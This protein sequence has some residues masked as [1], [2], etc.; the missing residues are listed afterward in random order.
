MLEVNDFNAIRISLASPDQVRAWSY[1]EVTKPETINYRTLKPEKDGLF[2]ERI[3]GPTKDWECYCGK[4]KR[5][6]FKGIVCDKC[7]VEVARSK[8]RRERMGHIELASPVSHIWYFKGTPSRIGLLLDLSPR[9]LERILYFALYV[10]TSIDEEA[11]Q[12]ELM[13]IDEE[14]IELD[15]N[16]DEKIVARI[17]S[18]KQQRDNDVQRAKSEADSEARSIVERRE[19]S[20]QEEEQTESETLAQLRE[21]MGQVA[22]DSII[23]STT[24]QTLVEQGQTVTPKALEALESA[25]SVAR[26]DIAE[27]ARREQEAARSASDGERIN[28]E[29]QA[30]IDSAQTQFEKDRKDRRQVLDQ[31]RRDLE[32]LKKLDLLQENRY[33]ELKDAFSDVFRAG[34]GAEA[35]RDLIAAIDLEKL[36]ADLRNEID[37]TVGQ[38][39][40]KATKRLKV[41]EA[42]RKSNT[43]PEW[44]ILTVLPVLPPDLRPMVQLDGG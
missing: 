24:D 22:E 9:N 7:G 5:V 23:F 4:Y 33:R 20:L 43:S 18:L 27:R 13:R 35:V 36:A 8:V 21:L 29:Y 26:N 39:R 10:V 28:L 44:M 38:R 30:K 6:R 41:V 3:F 25:G 17:E 15:Q 16:Q 37:S 19:A 1:G 14:M 34:M 12:R 11:R 42:F 40:K 2:C 32:G 31:Q